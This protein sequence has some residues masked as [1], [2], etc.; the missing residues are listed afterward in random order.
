MKREAEERQ[1]NLQR[2][3]EED[4]MQQ[5][6]RYQQKIKLKEVQE[7]DKM[8]KMDHR[9]NDFIPAKSHDFAATNILSYVYEKKAH[10]AYEYRNKNDAMQN[11]MK[12]QFSNT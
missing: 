3:A 1:L 11:L 8:L 7:Q 6:K 5:N 12:D 4:Q 10:K 9:K 2:L